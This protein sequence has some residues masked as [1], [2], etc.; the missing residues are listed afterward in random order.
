MKVMSLNLTVTP[1]KKHMLKMH[2]NSK[3]KKHLFT[4]VKYVIMVQISK[5]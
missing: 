1:V 4:T 2:M 5:A 3:H